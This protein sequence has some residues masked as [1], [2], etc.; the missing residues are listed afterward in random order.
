[1]STRTIGQRIASETPIASEHE[2]ELA[3]RIDEAIAEAASEARRPWRLQP[4]AAPPPA[5]DDDE[6]SRGD[7]VI[8]ERP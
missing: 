7:V 4:R 6:G 2:A 5:L 8:V 1:M 3:R